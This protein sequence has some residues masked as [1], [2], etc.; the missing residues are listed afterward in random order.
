M[1]FLLALKYTFAVDLI[2]KVQAPFR[3]AWLD[4][5]SKPTHVEEALH[6]F[7]IV[8]VLHSGALHGTVFWSS[9]LQS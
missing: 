8:V 5:K 6:I 1:S 9:P 2:K 7:A 4:M 3:V